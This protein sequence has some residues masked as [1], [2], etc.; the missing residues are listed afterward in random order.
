MLLAS[1]RTLRGM[2]PRH[3][4]AL[5]TGAS[6]GLGAALAQNLASRGTRVVLV[7]RNA[8][9]LEAVVRSIRARG[10]EAHALV[11]DVADKH[12]VYPLAGAAAELVGPVD[13]VIHNASALGPTPLRLLLDTECEDLE[14]VLAVNLVG[15]FRL[16]KALAGAM[17]LRGRGTIVHVSSD[18][19]VN[20]Y[21]GWGAY[22]ASKAALDHLGR[23]LAAE[24][25]PHGVRVLSVDPGDMNTELHTAA[26]P[27]ADPSSLADPGDV[28]ARIARWLDDD[29]V[30]SGSRVE[31]KNLE[32]SS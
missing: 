12:A 18:A 28:A 2:Q 1:G 8:E 7:A 14:R 30:R 24:L 25:A 23:V 13:L 15:P 4:A 16:T 3:Q 17:A 32:V 27:D 26:I 5:V 9:P 20:A 22:S 11:A 19:S 21:S 10:G 29:T 6:R 31:A